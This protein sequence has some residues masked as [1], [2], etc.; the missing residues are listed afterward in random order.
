MSGELD[1]PRRTA[2][3][4]PLGPWGHRAA[5][6][7]RRIRA[8]DRFEDLAAWLLVS[9]GLLATF[10][11]AF[12]GHAAYDTAL[13]AGPGATA[14]RAVVLA[15]PGP[16]PAQRMPTAAPRVP[17]AWSDADGGD[18]I[19][20]VA[21]R[22]PASA[23]SE[24]TVWLDRHGRAAASP[25]GR[26]AAFASGTGAGLAV[27]ALAWTLVAVTW[28]GVRCWIGRRNAAAWEREWARVEPVWS[29][30]VS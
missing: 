16:P 30:R 11:A 23:G 15:D 24:V 21:L 12:V 7:P 3:R 27:A 10:G 20:E 26:A 14:V 19:A 5:W 13:G 8:T 2:S 29:R 9:L 1:R 4:W 18:R 22:T 28:C 6:P 25:Q 17:V